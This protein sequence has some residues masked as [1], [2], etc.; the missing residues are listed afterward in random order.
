MNE[1]R[2]AGRL[3]EGANDVLEERARGHN[4]CVRGR[5]EEVKRPAVPL[6][7]PALG[8]H[9]SAVNGHHELDRQE[10]P[11]H[12]EDA[13]GLDR[14]VHVDRLDPLPTDQPTQPVQ[15]GQQRDDERHAAP[16]GPGRDERSPDVELVARESPGGRLRPEA[17]A[18]ARVEEHHVMPGVRQ[19]AAKVADDGR[20]PA[21]LLI[22]WNHQ[23][24]IHRRSHARLA[25]ALTQPPTHGNAVHHVGAALHAAPPAQ[26][27]PVEIRHDKDSHVFPSWCLRSMASALAP[28]NRGARSVTTA[29]DSARFHPPDDRRARPGTR[30]YAP[31]PADPCARANRDHAPIGY[32]RR[33]GPGCRRRACH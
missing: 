11:Q 7:L 16:H 20:H 29:P 12:A 6:Q 3:R 8:E 27:Q 23:K 5:E 31:A 15:R 4:D 24:D 26:R 25:G 19:V 13:E 21:E 2:L 33:S 18:L 32:W 10:P 30:G 28:A 17:T 9:V 14:V 1:Q 22:P